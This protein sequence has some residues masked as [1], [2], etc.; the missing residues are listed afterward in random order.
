ME[1]PR[2]FD[3]HR[4]RVW[5]DRL[6]MPQFRFARS[7]PR[8]GESD[9]A[10]EIRRQREEGEAREAVMTFILGLVAEP[11]PQ[12]FVY[13]PG[14]ERLAEAKG[15]QLLDKYNCIGC[16]QV[17]PGV[18]DF[19]PTKDTLDALEK[20]YQNYEKNN[21]KKDH[22]FPGHNAWTGLPSPWPDRLVAHGTQAHVANDEDADRDMFQLRLTEALR[23]ANNDKIIRDIPAGMQA[24]LI[25]EDV[26]HQSPPYG[27]TFAELLIPY[28]AQSNSTLYGGKP[29]EARSVLPP[30]LIREGERVQPNWLYWFLL[31][32]GPIRPQEKMKLRMPKFNMSGEDAM[33]LVNYF[34]AADKLGNPG[35]GLTTPYLT[36]PEAE[37]R[38]W[39]DMN[40]Q[41]L[42]RLKAVGGADGKG[43]DERAKALL[44]QLE[45]GVKLR[46]ETV[47]AAAM[48]AQGDD[49]AKK[50]QE[51]KDLQA[52]IDKWDKEIKDGSYADLTGQ[53]KSGDAYAADAYRLIAAN[54]NLCT[55]CHS[56]GSLKIEGANGPDLSG[57][58]ERLRP[59]WTMEWISNPDRMFGYAPTMP[60]NFAKDSLDYKEFLAGDVRDRVRAA[61]DAL[62]DLPRLENLPAD[63]ATRTAIT[64][65]K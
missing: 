42:E 4:I 7:R 28:L 22:V 55:K 48:T 50:E 36:I 3:Y 58:F 13:T 23:F 26:F 41:Y 31:N 20:T 35:A 62:M 53:W 17:R 45:A 38:Y 59:E 24:K 25:P 19:K 56:I 29:D 30:P 2:S 12:K 57:A 1:E 33:T 52:T 16:H 5:D 65:G 60:Q 14:P 64:G 18:Y 40:N 54:P 47:K 8:A 39:R 10:Y 63:R 15:R 49:K 46:L 11:I 61:R 27:G 32:P 43:L 21:A 34:G 37:T 44:T 9:E 6:R 51:A